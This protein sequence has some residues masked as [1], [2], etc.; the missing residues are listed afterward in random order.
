MKWHTIA[1]GASLVVAGIVIGALSGRPVSA[2][3][4][5]NPPPAAAVAETG[6][7]RYQ[8]SL[9]VHPGSHTST[10]VFVCD[11]STGQCWYRETLGSVTNWTD[12]GSAPR[13]LKK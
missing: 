7:G 9:S 13:D 6:A 11:T 3:N 10:T 5:P 1:L 8:M 2:Q 12:M 4:Q